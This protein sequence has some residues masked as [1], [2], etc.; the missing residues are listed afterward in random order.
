MGYIGS[1]LLLIVNLAMVMKP[2][3]FGLPADGQGS[4]T[5]MRMSF[6]MVGIWWMGFSQYTFAVLPKGVTS[7]KKLT[8][9]V[10]FNGYNELKKVLDT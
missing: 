5:A 8:K 3:S 9:Q 2:E 4:I 6:I 10:V 7:G 1:V